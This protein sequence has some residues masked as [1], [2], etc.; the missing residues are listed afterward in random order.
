MPLFKRKQ[1][2]PTQREILESF[3]KR[4]SAA[5]TLP[6]FG[7]RYLEFYKLEEEIEVIKNSHVSS[8]SHIREVKEVS[9]CLGLGAAVAT[10][11]F[12]VV[13]GV[14]ILM[15]SIVA[16]G[17]A[18]VLPP[19]LAL[20]KIKKDRRVLGFEYIPALNGL[21]EKISLKKADIVQNHL[22]DLRSSPHLKEICGR[23]PNVASA[24]AV[25]AAETGLD[26]PRIVRLDKATAPKKEA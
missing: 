19:T 6:D 25:A 3:E 14:G 7:S 22:L 11:A 5:E 10:G 16:L 21:L 24:F 26:I 8:E 4:I 23:F 1:P 17:G 2:Q 9:A 15:G 13:P 18:S 20:Y 12:F